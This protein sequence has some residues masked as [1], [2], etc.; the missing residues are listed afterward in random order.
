MMGGTSREDLLKLLTLSKLDFRRIPLPLSIRFQTL[1]IYRTHLS[2]ALY[3][4]PFQCSRRRDREV[5]A[6]EEMAMPHTAGV[7]DRR[8]QRGCGIGERRHNTV[9]N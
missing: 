5:V 4:P 3:Q 9:R 8:A 6:Q 1:M 2:L 7:V